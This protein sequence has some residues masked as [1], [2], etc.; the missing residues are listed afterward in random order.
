MEKGV[1]KAKIEENIGIGV[2]LYIYDEKGN[3][4]KDYLQDSLELVKIQAEE[5][6]FIPRNSWTLQVDI[7]D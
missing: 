2:Y 5:E 6:Y 1:L 3:C 4:I 7:Q